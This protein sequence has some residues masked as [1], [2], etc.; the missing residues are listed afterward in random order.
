MFVATTGFSGEM[1]KSRL[2]QPQVYTR[3]V[4][5][6]HK[7]PNYCVGAAGAFPCPVYCFVPVRWGVNMAK[8][9]ISF[10]KYFWTELTWRFCELNCTAAGI[11]VC[12]AINLVRS[13]AMLCC[14]VYITH[15]RTHICL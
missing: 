2:L 9:F 5:E 15:T 4:N 10:R 8:L 11:C 1:L 14:V 12:D 7:R 13:N 3:S 6:A